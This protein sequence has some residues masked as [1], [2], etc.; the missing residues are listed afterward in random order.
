MICENELCIYQKD[1][2]CCLK[3]VSINE[4]GMCS[5]AILASIPAEELEQYKEKTRRSL[6]EAEQR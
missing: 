5:E 2:S 4:L 3:T 6:L 1:K